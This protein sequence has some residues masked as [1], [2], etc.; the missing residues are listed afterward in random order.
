M[1]S[2]G[3][4]H[5]IRMAAK[6]NITSRYFM[7]ENLENRQRTQNTALPYIFI[8]YKKEDAPFGGASSYSS[9][10]YFE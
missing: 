8:R 5:P 9:P 2:V 1:R 4:E 7:T 6:D 10:S 3:S